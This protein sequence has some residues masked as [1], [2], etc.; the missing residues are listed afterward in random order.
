MKNSERGVMSR[1][2]VLESHDLAVAVAGP[3]TITFTL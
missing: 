1:T 2:R 3:T